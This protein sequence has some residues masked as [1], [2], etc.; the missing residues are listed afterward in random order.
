M[1]MIFLTLPL[2]Y[3]FLIILFLNQ[4]MLNNFSFWRFECNNAHVFIHEMD[5]IVFSHFRVFEFPHLEDD[6]TEF[7]HI[8]LEFAL[9]LIYLWCANGVVNK[10]IH[11]IDDVILYHAQFFWLA[12]V[13]WRYI[14][15]LVNLYEAWVDETSFRDLLTDEWFKPHTWTT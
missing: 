9:S 13:V 5:N 15:T 6:Q 4:K 12:V 3:F 8:D 1:L 11:V 7:L 2:L 14:C 10:N